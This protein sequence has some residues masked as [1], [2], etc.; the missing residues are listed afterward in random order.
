VTIASGVVIGTTT[1]VISLPTS[2]ATVYNYLGIPFAAPPTGTARFAPPSTPTSWSLPLQATNF[3]P[4]C[5]QQFDC[6][7]L[8][9]E[10]Y[11]PGTNEI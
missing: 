6:Q 8:H 10:F 1:S 5:M 9:T 7:H 3:P 11:V 4:A 2:T